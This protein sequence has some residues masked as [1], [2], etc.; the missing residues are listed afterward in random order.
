MEDFSI[1][2]FNQDASDTDDASITRDDYRREKRSFH[3]DEDVR[4]FILAD[5]LSDDLYTDKDMDLKGVLQLST[6]RLLSIREEAIKRD[7][8]KD[9]RLNQIEKG[10]RINAIYNEAVRYGAQI[11]LRDTILAYQDR[12]KE[13]S[14]SLESNFNFGNY[15]LHKNTIIPPI[16]NLRQ[17]GITVSDT[18]FTKTDINYYISSQA[19]FSSRIPNYRDYLSFNEYSVRDPSVFNVPQTANEVTHWMNGI[20]D[21]WKRGE[22]QGNIEIDNATTR[23]KLDFL[24]MVRYHMLSVKKM[25][26]EPVISKS[27]INISG[28]DENIE[29]GVVN[30]VMD[31]K[32]VFELDMEN[33]IPLPMIDELEMKEFIK[34]RNE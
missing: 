33:W 27:K 10:T 11:A 2:D 15:M 7:D 26:S 9:R 29:V 1:I 25:V 12:I 30:F 24:G 3:K 31:G 14:S 20:Y 16:I 19:R 18:T 21:G 6:S 32:P 34:R 22:V 17:D 28:D 8:V 23:L 4:K 5:E 13:E